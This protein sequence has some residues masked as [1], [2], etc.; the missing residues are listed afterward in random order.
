LIILQLVATG[1][2]KE[3][4]GTTDD[5]SKHK[6]ATRYGVPIVDI[7]ILILHFVPSATSRVF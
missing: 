3:V 1:I 4:V 2:N 6:S 5:R 7:A